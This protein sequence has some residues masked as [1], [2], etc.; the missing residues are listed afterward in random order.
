MTTKCP[1][2]LRSELEALPP[3]LRKL[4]VDARGYPVPWFVAW[5]DGPDGPETI[6]EFRAMDGR[7]WSAAVKQRLCWVCGEMLGRWLAFPIGPMCAITRTT[8]EPPSHLE[9]AEW[10]VRN[11]PF[12]SQ[13]RM[14]RREDHLPAEAEMPAGHGIMRNPGV[15]CI[16]TTRGYELFDD[17]RGKALIT[18]GECER[19]TWW[20]EGRA[21]TRAEVETSVAG[22]LPILLEEAKRQGSFA[23]DALGQQYA[24]A[25]LLFPSEAPGSPPRVAA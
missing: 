9:C 6:P 7:K 5:V 3:R 12:L 17:G 21:A 15:T 10:S 16:W 19:A 4:P 25:R 22:G 23:V 18:I 1:V 13:P 2:A 11:C 20:S 24:R 14:V 8:A